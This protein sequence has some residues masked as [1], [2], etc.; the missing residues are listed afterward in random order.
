MKCSKIFSIEKRRKVRCLCYNGIML[1]AKARV[2]ICGI[3]VVSVVSGLFAGTF[4]ARQASADVS[5]TGSSS[6]TF[7]VN[8]VESLTV[9]VTTPSSW[10]TGDIDTF[11]R[12]PVDLRVV[13]NNPDGFT[14]TMYSSA[15]TSLTNVAKS[16][17]TL[18][19]LNASTYPSGVARSSFP[20]NN[21]GYSLDDSESAG[22]YFSMK[23]STDPITIITGNGSVAQRDMTQTIYFGA[24]ANAAQASGTYAG[25]VVINVVTG[26]INSETNPETPTNPASSGA[27]GVASYSTA[28]VGSSTDYSGTAYSGTTSYTETDGNT[29]STTISGGDT[30]SAY[31]A[32]A[33][34]TRTSSNNALAV[35]LATTA[36]VAA[37]SSGI[38]FILAKR[39]RDDDDEEENQA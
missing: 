7:Q 11:L 16:S 18:P 34:V 5:P 9:E 39:S 24:K 10:A 12:N 1:K 33:G 2:I 23:T 3:G 26:T 17:A 21:W 29:K 30:R 28:G 8:V 27:D 19:T 22:T 37:V 14:A 32:P 31:A 6:A 4:V 25:T 36:G 38:F 13:S 20:A 15:G 35:A